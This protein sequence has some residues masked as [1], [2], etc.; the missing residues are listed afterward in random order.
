MAHLIPLDRRAASVWTENG[1]LVFGPRKGGTTLFQH[2]LDGGD[3]LLVYPEELK[4]KYFA[5]QLLDMKSA[6]TYLGR[7]R[8]P[9][10]TSDHLAIATYLSLWR[11]AAENGRRWPVADLIRFD[12]WCL[13]QSID[14]VPPRLAMWCAKEVGGGSRDVVAYWRQRFPRGKVLMIVR[15]PHAVVR[16]ILN[17]RRRKERQLSATEIG[18][19]VF[20]A[21]RTL[22]RQSRYLD[23]PAT[24]FT[25]YED[26]IADPEREMRK[27]IAFLQ[28]P[29]SDIHTRPTL[30]GEPVVVRTASR[31][32]TEV[33]QSD[34]DWTEGLTKREQRSV[35]RS[36]G[37]IQAIPGASL[38]YGWLREQIAARSGRV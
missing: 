24:H 22:R 14:D 13:A 8:I 16:A 27:V 12:A 37:L 20:G 9:Q 15:D 1:I 23:D 36:M 33:F 5:R 2:L 29:W 38:D 10:V 19:E 28:A 21:L 6:A 26:L 25:V 3:A 11:R 35:A 18:R 7:S 4:L 17:D 30:F 32:T 34:I 31:A